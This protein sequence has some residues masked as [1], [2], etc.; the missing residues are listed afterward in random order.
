MTIE[1]LDSFTMWLAFTY[2]AILFFVLELPVLKA[3]EN[4]VPE[5]FLILRRH[6]PVALLCF[7]VGG[8]WIIE[9][10]LFKSY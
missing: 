7:W 3:V 10:F 9:E 1:A 8:L 6:Q 4:R 5:L 2:G